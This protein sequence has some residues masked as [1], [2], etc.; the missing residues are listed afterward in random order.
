MDRKYIIEKLAAIPVRTLAKML[1]G[2]GESARVAAKASKKIHDAAKRGDQAAIFER[3]QLKQ[4]LI[5]N[6]QSKDA[7]QNR[8]VQIKR[9]QNAPPP[10]AKQGL[11]SRLKDK[12]SPS[13]SP[14]APSSKKTVAEGAVDR[15]KSGPA[16]NVETRSFA[17][18][19]AEEAKDVGGSAFERAKAKGKDVLSKTKAKVEEI[20]GGKEGLQAMKNP[21][22]AGAVGG[23]GVGAATS[24]DGMV[25]GAI[26]GAVGGATLG[27]GYGMAKH[28][29]MLK[30]LKPTEDAA[31]AVTKTASLRKLALARRLQED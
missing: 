25:R 20:A 9:V 21:A 19:A 7:L 5:R 29:G 23:A 4:H 3:G 11:F 2:G 27:A 10:A 26:K 24:D 18:K 8:V 16:K 17:D 1:T 31:K 30:A 14:K 22:L 13:A 15:L 12:I 6:K 28:K